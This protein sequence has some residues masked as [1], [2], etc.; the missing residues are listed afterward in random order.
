MT[1]PCTTGDIFDMEKD[2][3]CFYDNLLRSTNGLQE[4]EILKIRAIIYEVV[5]NFRTLQ[6]ELISA[7]ARHRGLKIREL[8]L[9]DQNTKLETSEAALL[10]KMKGLVDMQI[11]EIQG[12]VKD[13][14][15]GLAVVGLEE[16][17][18]TVG[19]SMLPRGANNGR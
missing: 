5:I 1:K 10:M 19:I 4:D 18:K 8:I 16:I 9:L 13:L 14:M 15:S 6:T 17:L 12:A 11:S 3:M 2:V 7:V